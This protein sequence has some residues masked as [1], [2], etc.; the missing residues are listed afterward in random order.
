MVNKVMLVGR[1]GA[2]PEL[3]STGGQNV[4]SN[5]NLATTSKSKG[6]EYTE[7]H[8]LVAWNNVGENM[9]KYCRKGEILWVQGRLQTR[10]WE[11]QQGV[12]RY[13]TEVVVEQFRNL[14]PKPSDGIDNYGL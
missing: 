4:V 5:A 14:S 12:K 10:N 2:D 11:D 7:W 8:R 9:E 1:L 13:T 3:K 6:Q